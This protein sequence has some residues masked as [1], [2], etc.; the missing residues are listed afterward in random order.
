MECVIR[1][2]I[3]IDPNDL[4]SL[5]PVRGAVADEIREIWARGEQCELIFCDVYRSVAERYAE[6]LLLLWAP[7][8]ERAGFYWG[9]EPAWTDATSVDDAVRRFNEDDLDP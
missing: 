8:T 6:G 2:Y 7:D 3:E 9:G 5:E 4:D 1:Y